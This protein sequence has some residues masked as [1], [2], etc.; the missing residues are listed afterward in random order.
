VCQEEEEENTRKNR[1]SGERKMLAYFVGLVR[2]FADP[3]QESQ[4][5]IFAIMTYHDIY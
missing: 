1:V 3:N 4:L 2:W 5:L